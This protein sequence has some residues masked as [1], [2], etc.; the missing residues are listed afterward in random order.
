MDIPVVDL[1]GDAAVV[2]VVVVAAEM[3]VGAVD[4]KSL[5]HIRVLGLHSAL[6]STDCLQTP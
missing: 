3:N 1:S 6:H 5:L 4:R 2:V